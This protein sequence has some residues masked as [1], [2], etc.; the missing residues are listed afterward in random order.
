MDTSPLSPPHPS[1]L[2]VVLKLAAL[3]EPNATVRELA[4][5]LGLS[6]SSVALSLRRLRALRLIGGDDRTR[7]VNR[8]AL[9]SC[10]EHAVRWIAPA[11]LG[12]FELGLPTAHAAP[13]FAGKLLGDDDPVVMPL[14]H[15][16]MRG[17]AVPPLHPGAPRAA[18]RDP[19]LRA[20]LAIVDA[21]RVGRARD[22]MVASEVLR[23]WL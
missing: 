6:K 4:E 17:R 5:E 1:D 21:F 7:R 13:P 12:D 14:P 11:E 20:L 22:R 9:R 18:A 8:M 19:K 3:P 23:K 10:L 2:L 15:G 16:P